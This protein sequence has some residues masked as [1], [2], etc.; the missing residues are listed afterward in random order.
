M[1]ILKGSVWGAHLRMWGKFSVDDFGWL[2][3]YEQNLEKWKNG[4]W[5]ARSCIYIRTG[6]GRFNFCASHENQEN[7]LWG[8]TDAISQKL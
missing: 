3:V 8:M 5:V 1:M 2:Y 4:G 6:V 7:T